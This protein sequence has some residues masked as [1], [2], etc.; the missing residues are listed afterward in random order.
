MNESGFTLHGRV[1]EAVLAAGC[2]SALVKLA[3][4]AHD[5]LRL[6]AVWALQ[7]LVYQA[8]SGVRKGPAGGP[9]MEP[10]YRSSVRHALRDSGE[11]LM[12]W[13]FVSLIV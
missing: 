6:N 13:T 8:N 4:S 2:I 5:E 1:Q 9:V 7:N 3:T 12:K 10:S 11:G